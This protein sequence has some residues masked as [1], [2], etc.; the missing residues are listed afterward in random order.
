MGYFEWG[1]IVRLHEFVTPARLG[2]LEEAAR[3]LEAAGFQEQAEA[4]RA[5][6]EEL[7][8]ALESESS[9]PTEL[10]WG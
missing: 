9:P 1:Q 2:E 7:A 4:I 5:W 8:K 3:L 6:V 10:W